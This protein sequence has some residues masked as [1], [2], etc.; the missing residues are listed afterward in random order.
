LAF[1]YTDVFRIPASATATLIF[2]VGLLGAFVFTPIIGILADRTRTRWGKFRPWILWTAL[3]FGA[4]SLAA[5]NT[6]ALGEHGKLIYAFATYT[7]LMLVYVANNLPYSALSGVLTGAGMSALQWP[8]DPPTSAFSVFSAGGILAMIVGIG[9]SKRLADRYGKR[10][11][12]GGA[13]LMSTLF[14]LA[15]YVYSP[16]AIGWVFVSYVLHGF[17]YGITIPLL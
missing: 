14:L 17:F 15:F 10:N 9:F 2:V 11:V 16:T 5:F 13:L 7:L 6:P 12:F 8:Q 4:L 1:F 3:P